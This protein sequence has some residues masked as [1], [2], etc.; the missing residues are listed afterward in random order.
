[1]KAEDFYP[2]IVAIA[3]Q[4]PSE[5]GSSLVHLYA[6][7]VTSYLNTIRR[8]GK[9][10]LRLKIEAKDLLKISTKEIKKNSLGWDRYAVTAQ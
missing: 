1:M 4:P 3:T 5:R 6:D 10:S 7:I 8:K 9:K 2:Q